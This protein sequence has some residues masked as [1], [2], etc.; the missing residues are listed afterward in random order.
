MSQQEKKNNIS[1]TYPETMK[2]FHQLQ[3]QKVAK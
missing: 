3:V 2:L 1:L